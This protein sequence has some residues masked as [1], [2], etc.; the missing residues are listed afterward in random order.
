MSMICFC[1]LRVLEL[2]DRVKVNGGGGV[3]SVLSDFCLCFVV[4]FCVPSCSSKVLIFG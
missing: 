1:V 2:G 4:R 3:L